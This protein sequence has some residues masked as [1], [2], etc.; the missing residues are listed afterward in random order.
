MIISSVSNNTIPLCYLP[1]GRLAC[2]QRGNMVLFQDGKN[3]DRVP[4]SISGKERLLGWSKL[5]TRLFRFGFRA[6]AAVDNRHVVLSR[7]NIL[8]ELNLMSGELSK[9]WNSGEGIR[10]LVLSEVQ[11]IEGFKDG[12]YFGGYLHNN[13]KKPVNIYHRKGV[14][15]WE[16][17]FTFPEGAINHVHNIIADPYRQCVWILTGDFD[18]AAAIW[19]ATDGYKKVGRVAFGDQKWRGCVAFAI[20]EGILYATDSPYSK[21]HIYLMKEDGSVEI[22][23]DLCGSCIYGC[24]WKDKFVFS[25]T[26]EADGRDESLKELLFSKK[27]GEGIEDNYVRLYVGDLTNGFH[28]IYKEKKDWLP[29]IFQFG[30]FKFPAG[31]NNGDSLYFQPVAT[32]DND[33]SLMVLKG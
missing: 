22:V 13:E 25:S 4:V 30:A 10:P 2:Y 21:N 23:G 11:G 16:V 27:R 7:G 32:R 33:M 29:F 15:D 28:V 20:P 5:A 12:I 8:H 9:G 31:V 17:A 1:D 26:V 6:A 3:T 24:Q 18:D 14:D 19:K